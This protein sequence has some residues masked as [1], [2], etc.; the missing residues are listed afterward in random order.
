MRLVSRL[1]YSRMKSSAFSF[2]FFM[3]EL[4]VERYKMNIEKVVVGDLEENCY[5]IKKNNNVLVVDPGD[6]IDKI[7]SVIGESKVVGVLVTH[8]H[9]DH[10]GAL[11][12]FD[13][14][15]I[16]SFSNLEEREYDVGGFKFE[17]IYTPGHTSDSVSYYFKDI[18]SLFCGDFI[19]YENIGRCDLPTGDFNVMK[20]SIYKIRKYPKDMKIYSGH[21]VDTTLVY[22]I[23]NNVYFK[24]V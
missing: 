13:K 16:Y 10:V 1:K 14:N 21:G 4:Y 6:E 23:E 20:E 5:V 7:N 24:E 18:N 11:S 15:I 17:V 22:E 12:Y 2:V 9:F 19:F 3:I 8:N